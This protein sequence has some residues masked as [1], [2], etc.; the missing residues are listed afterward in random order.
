MSS[1][2]APCEH[3]VGDSRQ[4]SNQQEAFQAALCQGDEQGNKN[5]D[6][7]IDDDDTT[8]L[9][10]ESPARQRTL[11]QDAMTNDRIAYQQNDKCDCTISDQ[12]QYNQVKRDRSEHRRHR[13]WMV[14]FDGKPV[15]HRVDAKHTKSD[16]E[17]NHEQRCEQYSRPSH[18]PGKYRL[19]QQLYIGGIIPECLCQGLTQGCT[20][21]GSGSPCVSVHK[22]LNA[23][24]PEHLQETA[25]AARSKPQPDSAECDIE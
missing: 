10:E 11:D 17:A 23:G 21:A 14:L 13:Q 16:R 12:V 18:E 2:A 3:G 19:F 9:F 1:V 15:E 22:P 6:R 5:G 8:P 20:A 25:K 7:G 24:S 4:G